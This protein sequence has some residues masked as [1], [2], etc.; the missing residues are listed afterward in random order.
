MGNDA[1]WIWKQAP[2]CIL[3]KALTFV[4]DHIICGREVH[5]F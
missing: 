4:K 5:A 1:T 3:D 2:G